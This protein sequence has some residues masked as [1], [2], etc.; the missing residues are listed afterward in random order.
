VSDRSS[1]FVRRWYPVGLALFGVAASLA[2]Y[3]RLPESI[4]MHW[5]LDGNPNGWMPRAAGAF[6]C[7]FFLLALAGLMRV[8][9]RLDPREANYAGFRGAY[10]AIVA[11]ALLLLLATHGIVLAVAL[12]YHV[13]VERLVPALVGALFVVIGNAMP[14]MLPNWWFGIRTPWTLS[15]DRVWTRTHRLAGFSMTAA[16]LVM[17]GAALALPSHLGGPVMLAAAVAAFIAPA[18]YSYLTWKREQRQ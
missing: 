6:F 10:E 12:G 16:G 9:P 4:A 7:P 14:R 17:I 8:L 15:D 2:V 11:A 1:A 3:A 18:V 13:A 5:D